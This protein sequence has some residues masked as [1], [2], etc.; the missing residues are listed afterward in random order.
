MMSAL[1][2]ARKPPPPPPPPVR[3][4]PTKTEGAALVSTYGQYLSGGAG[5]CESSGRSYS[6]S[7]A[8]IHS[9]FSEFQPSWPSSARGD[10]GGASSGRK[11]YHASPRRPA[12]ARAAMQAPDRNGGAGAKKTLIAGALQPEVAHRQKPITMA[13]ESEALRA[14]RIT[15][16]ARPGW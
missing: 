1:I 5:L 6:A 2:S 7:S 15:L 8:R 10:A 9:G 16:Q 11:G 13:H 12:S 14:T 3:P 4:S